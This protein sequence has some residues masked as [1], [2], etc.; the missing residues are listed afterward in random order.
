MYI[1][2][3]QC[4]AKLGDGGDGDVGTHSRARVCRACVRVCVCACVCA[5]SKVPFPELPSDFQVNDRQ[6]REE[7]E[8]QMLKPVITYA[9]A[10]PNHRPHQCSVT[11]STPP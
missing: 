4:G 2:I 1:Y 9:L 5:C 3:K 8:L 6:R 11:R 7:K 10:H